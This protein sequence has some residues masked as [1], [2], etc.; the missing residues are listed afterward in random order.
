MN[1]GLMFSTE[2]SLQSS[3]TLSILFRSSHKGLD[4]EN[5]E[6]ELGVA[7]IVMPSGMCL[8]DCLF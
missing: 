7:L 2:C 4:S 3:V 6:Q 8:T 1:V 5:P